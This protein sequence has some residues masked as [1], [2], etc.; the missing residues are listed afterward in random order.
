MSTEDKQKKLEE[1]NAEIEQKNKTLADLKNDI[2]SRQKLLETLNNIEANKN[3]AEAAKKYEEEIANRDQQIAN[4]YERID[5]LQK[6]EEAQAAKNKENKAKENTELIQ[7]YENQKV[8]YVEEIQN[9]TI[10]LRKKDRVFQEKCKEYDEKIAGLEKTIE[11]LKE[12]NGDLSK[13]VEGLNKNVAELTKKNEEVE[14][15]QEKVKLLTSENDTLL[16]TNENLKKTVDERDETTKKLGQKLAGKEEEIQKIN[17][18]SRTE[19]QE[20]DKALNEKEDLI[21]SKEEALFAKEKTISKLEKDLETQTLENTKVTKLMNTLREEKER[22]VKELNDEIQLLRERL[23]KTSEQLTERTLAAESEAEARAKA[24]AEI[25][26]KLKAEA[27]AEAKRKAEEKEG[28]EEGMTPRAKRKHPVEAKEAI[29]LE[30]SPVAIQRKTFNGEFEDRLKSIQEESHREVVKLTQ[31]LES[32]E[33]E[34]HVKLVALED[35]ERRLR[36]LEEMN[37]TFEGLVQGLKKTILEVQEKMEKNTRYLIELEKKLAVKDAEIAKLRE[38]ENNFTFLLRD[39]ENQLSAQ[40]MEMSNKD[41]QILKLEKSLFSII[42]ELN[43]F[44][45]KLKAANDKAQALTRNQNKVHLQEIASKN[46]EIEILKEMIKSTQGVVRTKDLEISRLKSKMSYEASPVKL[47]P[48][49]G[50]SYGGAGSYGGSDAFKMMGKKDLKGNMFR[51]S[52]KR[53]LDSEQNYSIRDYPLKPFMQAGSGYENLLSHAASHDKDLGEEIA[54]NFKELY[55]GKGTLEDQHEEENQYVKKETRMISGRS[56][57]S[58]RNQQ[59]DQQ[60]DHIAGAG[61]KKETKED[62]YSSGNLSVVDGE[63]KKKK[64]VNNIFDPS[65][66]PTNAEEVMKM[67]TP[68]KVKSKHSTK[69]SIADT[70]EHNEV[71]TITTEEK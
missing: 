12:D 70:I 15:L 65:S 22:S 25:E 39:K 26:A 27:E 32:A 46:N 10:E 43:L 48:I 36:E 54:Q 51:L 3:P 64:H 6:A 49:G 17:A 47:P 35:K 9:M 58:G 59:A 5:A 23:E 53:T 44:K 52:E 50:G 66:E 4:L 24:E 34:N 45:M 20:Q 60:E 55:Q 13:E 2:Q 28:D 30:S 68:V 7:S 67:M 8:K 56:G 71:E 14:H 69:K 19:I 42:E 37:D 29:N 16:E 62:N 18:G 1:L 38:Y 31:L 40:K 41:A 33:A 61:T 57:R 11:G 21:K 63:G